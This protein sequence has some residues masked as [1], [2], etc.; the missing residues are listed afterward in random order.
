MDR[1]GTFAIHDGGNQIRR[2]DGRSNS[3]HFYNGYKHRDSGKKEGEPEPAGLLV[4]LLLC[5]WCGGGDLN[6]YALRR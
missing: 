5:G 2:R 3:L 4:S 6:P 1:K